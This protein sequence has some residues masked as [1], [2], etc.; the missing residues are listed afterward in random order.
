MSSTGPI[1]RVGKE[2]KPLQASKMESEQ[3]LEE[4]LVADMRILSPEWMCIGKQVQTGTGRI[5]ILA[6][7][8]DG[9]LVVVELKSS[10]SDDSP[11][12]RWGEG[13]ITPVPEPS[14]CRAAGS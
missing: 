3:Q 9:T 2:P 10:T 8:R 13:T 6:V 14:G 1:W 7:A 12:S 5:D 4:M 11:Y